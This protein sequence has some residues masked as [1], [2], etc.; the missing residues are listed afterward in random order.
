MHW[1]SETEAERAKR[2]AN[3]DAFWDS[4]VATSHQAKQPRQFSSCNVVCL[5]QWRV[6]HLKG[7]RSK[8]NG[9]LRELCR[10]DH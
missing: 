10:G 5:E 9:H 6:S 4:L 8:G 3:E 7:E 2:Q 1:L